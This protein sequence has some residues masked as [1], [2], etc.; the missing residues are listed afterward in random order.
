L[1][2]WQSVDLSPH[3]GPL[4][5]GRLLIVWVHII[6]F[7]LHYAFFSHTA[8][9]SNLDMEAAYSSEPFHREL[10]YCTASHSRSHFVPQWKSQI[11]LINFK[12]PTST[13]V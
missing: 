12:W 11:S 1:R 9:C 13:Y 7:P 8:Y 6:C 10:S 5:P 3:L 2:F 4:S